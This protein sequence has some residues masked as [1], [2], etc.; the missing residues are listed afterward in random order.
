MKKIIAITPEEAASLPFSGMMPNPVQRDP[1]Y[2]SESYL[3]LRRICHSR[4]VICGGDNWLLF[5]RVDATPTTLVDV[6]D[7]FHHWFGGLSQKKTVC[8]C[9]D[10]QIHAR[11]PFWDRRISARQFDP[12]V[13]I[14]SSDLLR[15]YYYSGWKS[16]ITH[17]K[18][19][20]SKTSLGIPQYKKLWVTQRKAHMG[21]LLGGKCAVCPQ[22]TDLEFHTRVRQYIEHTGEGCSS[23]WQY[24]DLQIIANNLQMFCREHHQERTRYE[25]RNSGNLRR[26][27]QGVDLVG[28]IY[29]N[30]MAGDAL[31]HRIQN[32]HIKPIVV[33]D[34]SK[35]IKTSVESC[36][37]RQKFMWLLADDSHKWIIFC[38]E[39]CLRM[40]PGAR[41]I[42]LILSRDTGLVKGQKKNR[43]AGNPFGHGELFP[44][45]E[46]PQLN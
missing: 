10:C 7:L 23:K 17:P 44:P 13:N 35:I 2:L 43:C 29:P 32:L 28:W 34:D 40:F 27:Y 1:V 21:E 30:K 33:P 26:I 14:T 18:P 15:P 6:P 11:A 12:N 5:E 41:K 37:H 25:K 8:I 16:P 46:Y 38:C 24:Y 9:I 45:I 39:R 36:G 4:C 19:L 42:A 3:K 20:L 31:S 22:V